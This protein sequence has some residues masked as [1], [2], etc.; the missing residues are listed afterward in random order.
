MLLGRLEVREQNNEHFL[1]VSA[2]FDQENLAANVMEIPVQHFSIRLDS[3]FAIADVHRW[4]SLL[5]NN[6]HCVYLT[7][8]RNCLWLTH[9]LLA[10]TL[11]S[12]IASIIRKHV[13]WLRLTCLAKGRKSAALPALSLTIL[14]SCESSRRFSF[15]SRF[16]PLFEGNKLVV[17]HRSD[18]TK[19]R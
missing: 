12:Q 6:V 5:R 16:E 2:D 18:A 1:W 13:D 15:D 14:P 17:R 8:R 4:R 19:G 10:L 11:N 3:V 9:L 7:L